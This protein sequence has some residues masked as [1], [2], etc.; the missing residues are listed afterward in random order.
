MDGDRAA[1]DRL[2]RAEVRFRAAQRTRDCSC[3]S[4][5]RRELDEADRE[6]T[7]RLQLRLRARQADVSPVDCS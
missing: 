6:V 1:G 7:R 3:Y 5:A 2:L 4:A